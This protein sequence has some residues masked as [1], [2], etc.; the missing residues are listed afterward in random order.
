MLNR[1]FL[2]NIVFILF[3]VLCQVL[4][5]N[6][7][8][9]LGRYNP[10]VFLCYILF[11]PARYDFKN[12]LLYCFLLGLIL[13]IFLNTLG[14]NA[15]CAIITVLVR[16]LFLHK[17]YSKGIESYLRISDL[18]FI[19]MVAYTFSISIFYNLLL[20]SIESFNLYNLLFS[21]EQ[22]FYNGLI[23][24]VFIMIVLLFFKNRMFE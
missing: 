9:F 21:L 8:N 24:F 10:L 3:L 15:F 11:A 22:G 13:D 20:Y 16:E 6:H 7:V 23:T 12:I 14:I 4:V 2:I 1:E 19:Q 5:F 18:S 17:L